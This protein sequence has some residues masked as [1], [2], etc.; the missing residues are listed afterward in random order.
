[1]DGWIES[2][3]IVVALVTVPYFSDLACSRSLDLDVGMVEFFCHQ[4][5]RL[6]RFLQISN[7]ILFIFQDFS[8][9]LVADDTP[10]LRYAC[11]TA[12]MLLFF[13]LYCICFRWA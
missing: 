3:T 12:S 4:I 10:L 5:A 7:Q 8:C 13:L 6:G 2:R 1:M 9:F 11:V